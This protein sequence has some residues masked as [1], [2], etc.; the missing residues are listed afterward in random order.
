MKKVQHILILLFLF[1]CSEGF[2]QIRNDTTCL[3]QI[4]DSIKDKYHVVTYFV[5]LNDSLI[6][7]GQEYC[8]ALKSISSI[9]I[10]KYMSLNFPDKIESV[11]ID[12]KINQDIDKLKPKYYLFVDSMPEFNGGVSGLLNFI[13]NNFQYPLDIDACCKI[14]IQFT[15][16]ES[17]KMT[18]V[19]IARGLQ[20]L[21][22]KELLRVF[23]IMPDWK[24][25]K[26]DGKTVP[27]RVTLPI[28]FTIR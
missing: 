19:K 6:S 25:G 15:V 24:P 26:L 12:I 2:G 16:S 21:F 9:D 3:S 5:K 7:N 17:G 13:G 11:T 20:E 27:V 10:Y 8:F 23:S 28:D 18:D 22:D 14:Y 1:N 4:T